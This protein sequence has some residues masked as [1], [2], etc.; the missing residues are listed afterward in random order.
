MVESVFKWKINSDEFV[1]IA[2]ETGVR[3]FIYNK[4]NGN[5]IYD[6]E[7]ATGEPDDAI[8]KG[9]TPQSDYNYRTA[10]ENMISLLVAN[11]RP[12][13]FQGYQ[14]YFNIG[15]SACVDYTG[16]V[17]MCP[18]IKFNVVQLGPDEQAYTNLVESKVL[19]NGTYELTYEM[20]V[21]Q[22]A[23]GED[24]LRGD[25]G[26]RGPKGDKGDTGATGA[27]GEKGDDGEAGTPGEI[28]FL[29]FI[30][31]ATNDETYMISQA[32][33]A[34]D[35]AQ[36]GAQSPLTGNPMYNLSTIKID[37]QQVW[38][39]SIPQN[40]DGK[41]IWMA[42]KTF[43][44][45]SNWN[46]YKWSIPKPVTDSEYIDYEW[47]TG[48]TEN[49]TSTPPLKE[50][51]SQELLPE[52]NNGWYDNTMADATWMAVRKVENGEYAEG[53]Q[54]E[55]SRIKGEDG[56]PGIALDMGEEWDG[57][58]FSNRTGSENE[59][60]I[61]KSDYV[62]V[63]GKSY[64]KGHL[65]V[66]S[67]SRDEWTDCGL[68]EGESSY[69][70]IK[71][72][73][74]VT[75]ST[76]DAWNIPGTSIWLLWTEQGGETPGEYMGIYADND[77]VDSNE[78]SKYQ[79]TR[80]EGRDGFGYEFIFTATST[81]ETPDA[82]TGG[83]GFT[84]DGTHYDS[85]WDIN[86]EIYQISFDFVPD[87]WSDDLISPTAELPYV[88]ETYRRQTREGGWGAYVTPSLRAM[89]AEPPQFVSRVFKRSNDFYEDGSLIVAE[90]N[91][92]TQWC[93]SGDASG[94]TYYEPVPEGWNDTVP[95]GNEVL[96][97]T[98]RRF[99]P[100]S[101]ELK[102]SLWTDIVLAEDG[103]RIDREW[104]TGDTENTPD[105]PTRTTP[106]DEG[107]ESPDAH[108][109]YD[110][111]QPGTTWI[112]EC[113]IVG[114][115]YVQ[116][117]SGTPKWVISRIKGET[118][119]NAVEYKLVTNAATIV[120]N[121]GGEC[122]PSAVTCQVLKIVGSSSEP[123]APAD[124]KLMF[125]IDDGTISG[126]YRGPILSNRI[127][128]Q[129]TLTFVT[130]TSPFTTTLAETNVVKVKEGVGETRF[131]SFIFAATDNDFYMLNGAKTA[132]D[133]AQS[134]ATA[135]LTGSPMW[136][137]ETIV[138]GDTQLPLWYDSVPQNS[139]GQTIWMASKTFTD[140]ADW[141]SYEWSTPKPITDSE[142]IDYEWYTG[143]TETYPRP[144]L[145][146]EPSQQ[147]D[148]DDNN[149]W[150]DEPI[151]GATWMA[152]KKVKNGKYTNG[153]SWEISKIKGE[154]GE[155][156][157]PRYTWIGYSDGPLNDEG[158]PEDM[159][160]SPNPE[161]RFM[162][163]AQNK[164]DES[165]STNPQDYIWSEIKGD[166]G[167]S[168]IIYP[169]GTW[170]PE[171]TYTS[172][173]TTAPYVY[174]DD[175]EGES[176]YSGYYVLISE[177]SPSGDTPS[178]SE[179]W[180]KMK[181]YNAIYAKIVMSDYGK[182]GRAV[183]YDD[184]MFSEEGKYYS[185][186][187]STGVSSGN[188]ETFLKV[189]GAETETLP[190]DERT[191]EDILLNSAFVP[192][193][194][195][196]FK[197]GEMYTRQLTVGNSTH[198]PF[199]MMETSWWDENNLGDSD[200]V[201]IC[202]N[203]GEV[204]LPCDYKQN[205]RRMVL[206]SASGATTAVTGTK[207]LLGGSNS[208][209]FEDGIKKKNLWVENEI[210]ELLGYGNNKTRDDIYGWLVLNRKNYYT[211]GKY[212]HEARVLCYG[213]VSY[214]NST[215]H[216]SDFWA[217]DG[218]KATTSFNTYSAQTATTD[219]TLCVTRAAN[220]FVMCLPLAWAGDLIAFTT[221]CG[222][223][224]T[225][226]VPSVAENKSDGNSVYSG[227]TCPYFEFGCGYNTVDEV[228][229]CSFYFAIMNTKDFISLTKDTGDIRSLYSSI[230]DSVI[231]SFKVNNEEEEI[232]IT[233]APRGL[234]ATGSANRIINWY[235]GDNTF[236]YDTT[237]TVTGIKGAGDGELYIGVDVNCRSWISVSNNVISISKNTTGEVRR[238]SVKLIDAK[239]SSTYKEFGITQGKFV[240]GS[241]T[242]PEVQV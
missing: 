183:F 128:N 96:W 182:I 222:P 230:E 201:C 186:T 173:E 163:V 19:P 239:R 22:G 160:P 184:F 170:V 42:S 166:T 78:Y 185:G 198:V 75:P 207:I 82:P 194:F 34:L 210:V 176:G 48:T 95:E 212:G 87:G 80:S 189:R 106:D 153:S 200:N 100:D 105:I 10:F 140:G 141:D 62:V 110:E 2:D 39:D 199:N 7:V 53:S 233:G 28:R 115:A 119:E 107:H 25:T 240:S 151:S 214:E 236:A 224:A 197:T 77:V 85:D 50:Y 209:I 6:G 70:H 47:Y 98:E 64:I 73:D 68:V 218:T 231:N 97:M 31:A 86:S 35:D 116:D 234:T 205:G 226:S 93:E 89:Y 32:K 12:V 192:N 187:T 196:N 134:G 56:A 223:Y 227:V 45:R 8:I 228:N 237:E 164:L 76:A 30:F 178:E 156:G 177:E 235:Y 157:L 229:S 174:Y 131:V 79:W 55:I 147:L 122:T 124:G 202:D 26:E 61:C 181:E 81:T 225:F 38:Y 146:T 180:E 165:A 191:V 83:T 51:P 13:N 74:R 220:R 66:W 219:N 69:V 84:A 168:K 203:G 143:T 211:N 217:F 188:C 90:Q 114:G 117:S 139:N 149:G 36:S 133:N 91:K 112:A 206:L 108:G 190:S 167:T 4:T 72:A 16:S 113:E 49:P 195:I 172:T 58:T 132:L 158:Y 162:G 94:G 138:S 24:G 102:E 215:V 9:N 23:K 46:T 43:T 14:A 221:L 204:T 63:G 145:K 129:V 15:N 11:G 40:A 54:W 232:L 208:F 179:N 3:Q 20:G 52:E 144:P 169:E 152:I 57:E 5:R 159:Y 130:G 135:P 33:T 103:I 171:K 67:N 127:S 154:D 238:G 137:L 242:S 136:N 193:T 59:A 120:E 213:K 99:V 148:P 155:D 92:L 109:W 241:P 37:G 65:Y 41:T 175:G 216:I 118:G 111:P 21:P 27:R 71:Y 44:D 18:V 1:Y 142:Y 150:Y 29:S 104:Y 101:E 126:E 17:A 60:H 121:N 125:T 88:W 161:T 123:A